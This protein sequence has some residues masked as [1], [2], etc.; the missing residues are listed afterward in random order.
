MRRL[1]D[2]KILQFL[3]I[4]GIAVV[5]LVLIFTPNVM[6]LRNVAD[7]TVQFM[8]MFLGLGLLF[9]VLNQRDLM[10]ASL[11]A[12]GLLCLFLKWRGN[13]ELKLPEETTAPKISILHFNTSILDTNYISTLNKVIEKDPDVISIQELTPEWISVLDD[14]LKEK[15]P[16]DTK[17][18]RIDPY[19]MAIYSKFP[20]NRIDTFQHNSIPNL[21]IELNLEDEQD[22]NLISSFSLPPL[23]PSSFDALKEHLTIIADQVNQLTLPCI[24]LGSL[25]VVPWS[26]EIQYFRYLAD[27]SDS[28]RN[29]SSASA[30]GSLGLFKIPYDHIFYSDRL[31]C[32]GFEN[33]DSDDGNHLGIFGTYQLK[34]TLDAKKE[35]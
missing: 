20:I 24:T 9:L 11:I 22:L 2:N 6:W 30:G 17:L 19:G 14:F 8:L 4:G 16:D 32:I 29:I 34:M 12:C 15:Y 13:E 27:M 25:N 3:I 35:N 31:E 28:R 5:T 10:F 1:L 33:I 21:N 26:N 7:Y 18:F 23:N